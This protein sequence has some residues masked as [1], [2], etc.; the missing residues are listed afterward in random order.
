MSELKVQN[1]FIAGFVGGFFIM[2]I[3]GIVAAFTIDYGWEKAAINA[4]VGQ[5]NS[6]TSEFEFKKVIKVE[7]DV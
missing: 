1:I 4:G 2:L 5:Y 6:Q 3:L 7:V